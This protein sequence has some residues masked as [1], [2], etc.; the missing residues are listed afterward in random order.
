VK[1]V[2]TCVQRALSHTTTYSEEEARVELSEVLFAEGHRCLGATKPPI[3]VPQTWQTQR[4]AR[5]K[6]EGSRG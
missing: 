5:A 1:D 4:A 3:A 6:G 2:W